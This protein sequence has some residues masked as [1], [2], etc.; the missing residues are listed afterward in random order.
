MY[1]YFSRSFCSPGCIATGSLFVVFSSFSCI[2]VSTIRIN[3]INSL[4]RGFESSRA[5]FYSLLEKNCLDFCSTKVRSSKYLWPDVK[6]LRARVKIVIRW[7]GKVKGLNLNFY[8]IHVSVCV[9]KREREAFMR[10]NK[11]VFV[12]RGS[13]AIF[14]SVSPFDEPRPICHC[15]FAFCISGRHSS[16]IRKFISSRILHRIWPPSS[17]ASVRLILAFTKI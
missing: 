15:R 2:C 10:A 11:R 14:Y 13:Q 17:A 9:R 8:D 6:H 4:D 3:R 12:S 5:S 16:R 7:S 1:I